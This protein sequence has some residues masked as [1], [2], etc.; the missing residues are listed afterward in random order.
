MKK[1]KKKNGLEFKIDSYCWRRKSDPSLPILSL[2]ITFWHLHGNVNT[3]PQDN[4]HKLS[5]KSEMEEP[6]VN[7]PV[8]CSCH[9]LSQYTAMV[10]RV[11]VRSGYYIGSSINKRETGTE[12]PTT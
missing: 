2:A 7:R 1:T 6:S 4:S 5:V 8:S 12:F 3:C 9:P 10:A 11:G